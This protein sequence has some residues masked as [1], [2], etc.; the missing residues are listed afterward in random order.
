MEA[1][2]PVGDQ[3][4]P[5]L[6]DT[7][8]NLAVDPKVRTKILEVVAIYPELQAEL[9]AARKADERRKRGRLRAS[10]RGKGEK[11]PLDDVVAKQMAEAAG[12]VYAGWRVKALQYDSEGRDTL[13]AARTTVNALSF[14]YLKG[15]VAR[16]ARLSSLD[17]FQFMSEELDMVKSKRTMQARSVRQQ[18]VQESVSLSLS[19]FFA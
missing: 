11:G 7:V 3:Y 10:V 14:E 6:V 19:F 16:G 2:L 4:T 18:L 5:R 1:G 17:A 15:V 12:A 13:K 8:L 9:E